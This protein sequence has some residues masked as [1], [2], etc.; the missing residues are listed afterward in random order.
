LTQDAKFCHRMQSSGTGCKVWYMPHQDVKFDSQDAK[1]QNTCAPFS[2][3]DK[4]QDAKFWRIC[5]G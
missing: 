1:F 2:D 5:P 4:N 3:F